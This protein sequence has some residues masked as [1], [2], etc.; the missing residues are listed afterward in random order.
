LRLRQQLRAGFPFLR[1]ALGK[2]LLEVGVP[3]FLRE[4]GTFCDSPCDR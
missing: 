2:L 1:R 3:D 4:G